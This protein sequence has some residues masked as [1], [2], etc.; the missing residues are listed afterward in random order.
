MA[1]EIE[2]NGGQIWTKSRLAEIVLN[3][4]DSVKHFRL[5]DGAIVDGD[6]YM[7]AMP[8][9]ANLHAVHPVLSMLTQ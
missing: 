8:G 5:Q 3:E 9:T 4:D 1:E 2:K 7:S 6:L